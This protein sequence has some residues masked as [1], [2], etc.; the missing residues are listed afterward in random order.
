MVLFSIKTLFLFVCF[1][2]GRIFYVCL[3][4]L[5]FMKLSAGEH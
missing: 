2:F 5:L 3:F 1:K 4:V